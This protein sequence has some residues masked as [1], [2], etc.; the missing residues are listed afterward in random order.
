MESRS[1]PDKEVAEAHPA[2]A[3]VSSSGCSW[4]VG[5][6]SEDHNN[7]HIITYHMIQNLYLNDVDKVVLALFIILLFLVLAL[8]SHAS[9][10]GVA[11]AMLVG[12]TG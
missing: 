6:K 9:S 12:C 2:V 1:H 11:M 7:V 10:S 4:L 3:F 8:F 5:G